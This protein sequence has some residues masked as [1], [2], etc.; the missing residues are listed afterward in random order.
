MVQ[1]VCCHHLRDNEVLHWWLVTI[2]IPYNRAAFI[3]LLVSK[4]N[5][6][7]VTTQSPLLLMPPKEKQPCLSHDLQSRQYRKFELLRISTERSLF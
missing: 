4:D 1:T 3:S 7:G 2:E 6:W 5:Q